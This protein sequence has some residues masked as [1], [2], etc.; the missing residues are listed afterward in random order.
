M[1][2]SSRLSVFNANNLCGINEMRHQ[3]VIGP[4]AAYRG[5]YGK[6]VRLPGDGG[7]RGDSREFERVRKHQNQRQVGI[8]TGKALSCCPG[9]VCR[10]P[11][12]RFQSSGAFQQDNWPETVG[13][14]LKSR[15][16]FPC[17]VT[18]KSSRSPRR[19]WRR[20]GF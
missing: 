9:T 7:I 2:W 14:R 20:S 11:D 16:N 19:R 10:E 18:K 5:H 12:G 6:N 1:Y 13:A 4:P 3:A 8:V 17:L 15:M